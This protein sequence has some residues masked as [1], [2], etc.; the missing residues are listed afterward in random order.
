M[1]TSSAMEQLQGT[2]LVVGAAMIF[3]LVAL[4]VNVD[5]LPL[6]PATEC[7]FLVSWAVAVAFMLYYRKSRGLHWFGPK[8]LRFWLGLKCALSFIFITMWWGAIQKAPMGDCIAIIYCSPIV[9]SILSRF[10]LGEELP[11]EFPLQVIFVAAGSALVLDP[12][13]L[14]ASTT[15]GEDLAPEA[16]YNL[17][18]CALSVCSIIPIV[19]RKARNCSWIEVEHVSACMACLILDPALILAQYTIFGTVPRIPSGAP[20]EV[21]LI[22]LAAGG[23]FVGI[24]METKGYQMAEVGK[25]TMFRYLEVPFAYLLQKLGTTAP[26]Q[27]KALVGAAL[28]IS[29]CAFGALGQHFRNK[30]VVARSA[31]GEHL[32][33][34][35]GQEQAM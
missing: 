33:S 19:T 25:A 8:E 4:V 27:T 14:R 35:Q 31:A 20:L 7:R 30:K 1:D 9:T 23:S 34:E 28:I 6:L 16:D 32:L 17:V 13:F 10:L 29:S 11:M 15:V 18:Y 3:A 26:I 24:A 2:C 12:P 22:V 21:G 5:P